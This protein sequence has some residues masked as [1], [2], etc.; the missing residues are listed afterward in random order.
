MIARRMIPWLW[1]RLIIVAGFT[2][3]TAVDSS[4][5]LSAIGVVLI[6][7]TGAQLRTAY[8]QQ[9]T[10]DSGEHPEQL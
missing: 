4:W 3:Y 10:A 9:P 6:V 7:I 8:Q 5:Y 2:V 1:L